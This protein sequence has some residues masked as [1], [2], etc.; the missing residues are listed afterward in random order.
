MKKWKIEE[1]NTKTKVIIICALIEVFTMI[2]TL[3]FK[4]VEKCF[5]IKMLK[6]AENILNAPKILLNNPKI[7]V[8][9]IFMAVIGVLSFINIKHFLEGTKE[10]IDGIRFKEKDGTHGTARFADVRELTDI[11]VIGNEENTNGLIL[12]KTLDTDELI[13]LPDNYRGLN[14]NIFVLGASGSGK[15]R[16]FIVPNIL[17]IAEQEEKLKNI[18]NAVFERKNIVCTDPKGELYSKCCKMLESRGYKVKVFNMVKPLYSDGIDLIKLIKTELDAQIFAKII[19]NTTYDMGNKKSDE[20]WLNTQENLLIALLLHIVYE[21]DDESKKNMGYIHSLLASENLE[22]VDNVLKKSKGNIKKSYNVY[23][24][25]SDAVKQSV[26]TGLATKLQIFQIDHI[27]AITQ[28][29][30]IDFDDLDKEKMAIFCIMRDMDST[31]NFLCS[32]FFSFLFINV[33]GVAD[34]NKGKRLHRGL[35]LFLDEFP[36]IGQIPDFIK[37]LATIRTREI[38]AVIVCQNIA[39][40]ENLYPNNAWQAIIG[41]TD[42]RILMGCNDIQSADYFSRTLGTAT[43]EI[44]TTRK[45]GGFDGLMDIGDEGITTTRRNLMNPDEILRMKNDEQIVILRG[46]RPFKCKKFDYSEYKLAN[47]I[48]EIEITEHKEP[49][50][51]ED[52]RIE[53]QE[54]KLPTFEEFIE[55]KRKEGK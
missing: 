34:D 45:T 10:E 9:A 27:N 44:N 32:I 51:L 26:L 46:Q 43:V 22:K 12:G 31:M 23:A 18:E 24:K 25:E 55:M 33:V 39:G 8:I 50:I 6:G 1:L 15:S 53:N 21:E 7:I 14:R 52:K 47:E 35:V 29:N 11:L 41:N 49:I 37:K 38:S 3:Y 5:D 17:K 4:A 2:I 42:I 36:N 28:R 20:F 48:E 54:E 30:D 19:I 16:K 13:I 40:I